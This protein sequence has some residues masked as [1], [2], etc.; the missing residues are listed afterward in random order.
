MPCRAVPL[1]RKC[2][3]VKSETSEFCWTSCPERLLRS[4]RGSEAKQGGKKSEYHHAGCRGT[5]VGHRSPSFFRSNVVVWVRSD[6]EMVPRYPCFDLHHGVVLDCAPQITVGWHG[7]GAAPMAFRPSLHT[8]SRQRK[9]HVMPFHLD[10]FPYKKSVWAVLVKGSAPHSVCKQ[11]YSCCLWDLDLLWV[12]FCA[13]LVIG[14]NLVMKPP[15]QKRTYR[16]PCFQR[17]I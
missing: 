7:S 2:Y 15:L 13:L 11:N 4:T 10:A 8:S 1:L 14:G 6:L 9:L 12:Y 3:F 5:P 16:L 17:W